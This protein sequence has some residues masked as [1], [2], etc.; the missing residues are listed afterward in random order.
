MRVKVAWG[1][2]RQNDGAMT[3]NGGPKRGSVTRTMRPSVR[4][5][6]C[7]DDRA[8]GRGRQQGWGWAWVQVRGWAHVSWQGWRNKGGE[9]AK[10]DGMS[11]NNQRLSEKKT[12]QKAREG[13]GTGGGCD[14]LARMRGCTCET[15]VVSWQNERI[16]T[17]AEWHSEDMCPQSCPMWLSVGANERCASEA[18]RGRHNWWERSAGVST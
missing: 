3:S 15:G 1:W 12:Y 11:K 2:R 16:L 14:V 10:E 5:G 9:A 7:G 8:G 4:W 17:G 13:W 6:R 18:T